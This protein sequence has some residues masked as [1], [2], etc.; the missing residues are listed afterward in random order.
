[1]NLHDISIVE[2]GEKDLKDIY[3]V[4]EQAFGYEKEAILT[5]ELLEDKTARPCLSLLAYLEEEPIGHILFTRVYI[6]DRS[7]TPLAHILAPLAVKPVFQKQGVGGKLIRSG[8]EKLKQ[9]DSKI[10]LYWDI[11]A[12]TRDTGFHRMQ[13]GSVF[14][15]PI[16][17]HRSLPMPGCFRY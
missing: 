3:A 12:I 16:Q 9:M 17:S 2:T 14:Q 15:R 7:N 6:E 13:E 4:Q 11:W 10:V 8:L 1:M 5:L